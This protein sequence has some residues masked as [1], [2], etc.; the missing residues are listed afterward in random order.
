VIYTACLLTAEVA[1][2]AEKNSFMLSFSL[3]V[4]GAF[5]GK[6]DFL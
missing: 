3:G 1:E 4:L 6:P 2:I 5:C